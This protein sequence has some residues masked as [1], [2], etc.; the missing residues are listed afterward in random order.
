MPK[1]VYPNLPGAGTE[2]EF[3]AASFWRWCYPRIYDNVSAY[4]SP[5]R[6]AFD[7]ASIFWDHSLLLTRKPGQLP[8]AAPSPSI[9]STAAFH[10]TRLVRMKVPTFFVERDLLSALTKTTPPEAIDW[11]ALHLPFEAAVFI[12]PPNTITFPGVGSI[13]FLWYSRGLKG[14]SARAPVDIPN[15]MD[16]PG[17]QF[18]I[19]TVLHEAPE[20]PAIIHQINSETDPVIDLSAM[21]NTDVLPGSVPFSEAE[22]NVGGIIAALVFNLIL[23]MDARPELL[24]SGSSKGKKSKRGLEFWHPNIIGRSYR[25]VGAS[26]ATSAGSGITHRMHWRRGHW[27]NQGYGTGRQQHRNVWI[28]P[29][30]VAAQ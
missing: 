30:L 7:L 16:L 11:R 28:E 17:D 25:I 10:A 1:E 6:P 22:R 8:K 13:G 12:F 5:K 21:L 2:E 19:R 27:R 15:E 3:E 20:S 26:T 18:Y 23:A 14:Q 24:T 4:S 9:T 29:T